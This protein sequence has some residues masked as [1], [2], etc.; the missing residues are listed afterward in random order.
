MNF[1]GKILTVLICVMS[2]VF[3]TMAIMLYATHTNWYNVVM[4]P[5]PTGGQ[6]KGLKYQLQ[7]LQQEK[8]NLG[9]KF[10]AA[11][12]ELET[13]RIT[14]DDKLAKL[15]NTLGELNLQ[16]TKLET[17]INDLK[18]KTAEA[19]TAMKETQDTLAALRAE[20]ESL[21]EKIRTAQRE[22]DEAFEEAVQLADQVHQREIEKKRL[23]S[24]NADLAVDNTR[25]RALLQ[26]YDHDPNED[27]SGVLLRVS[28]QVLAVVGGDSVEISIGSDDGLKKGHQLEVFRAHGG[29][30]RYMGRVEIVETSPD[31]AVAKILPEYRKGA[32]Q[33]GDSV[34]SKFN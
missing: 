20:V 22:R 3:M 30:N 6:P 29:Q 23:E 14:K 21:R 31:K 11:K 4:L 1:V 28:G 5:Q 25:M 10:E 15:E 17:Q 12:K 32:I 2:L 27:P 7:D 26:A 18:L 16:R 9:D 33:E 24:K 19:V 13:E 8:K 34:V